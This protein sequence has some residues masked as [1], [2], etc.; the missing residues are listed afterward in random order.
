MPKTY[1]ESSTAAVPTV[2]VLKQVAASISREPEY[3]GNT[4]AVSKVYRLEEKVYIYEQK[5]V[6]LISSANEARISSDP[7]VLMSLNEDLVVAADS[8]V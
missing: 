7:N 8:F 3:E 1:S 6:N 4:A 5:L 2:D